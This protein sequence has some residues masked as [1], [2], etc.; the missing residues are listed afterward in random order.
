MAE[1]S[2]EGEPAASTT[3]GGW[4]SW[5]KTLWS[6]GSAGV[7]DE[8]VVKVEPGTGWLGGWFGGTA[9][10]SK[11]TEEDS[12]DEVGKSKLE[13]S[14]DLESKERASHAGSV[15]GGSEHDEDDS[16]S[17][18]ASEEPSRVESEVSGVNASTGNVSE[19]HIEADDAVK[20]PED[21]AKVA[22][23]SRRDKS[24]DAQQFS[25]S[26]EDA[27]AAGPPQSGGLW[28]SVSAW[29]SPAPVVVPVVVPCPEPPAPPPEKPPTPSP[30]PDPPI[31]ARDLLPVVPEPPPVNSFFLPER[32]DLDMFGPRRFPQYDG[33][34]R[35]W[36][37]AIAPRW[38]SAGIRPTHPYA[39][40][41]DGAEAMSLFRVS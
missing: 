10:T 35:G 27:K 6:Q 23:N 34:L 18:S 19:G 39:C 14:V 15:A 20:P 1:D 41:R 21:A 28:D 13:D 22:P 40:V 11:D 17:D 2:D 26:P 3:Q 5:Y 12:D 7:E 37:R 32:T 30:P 25:L 33:P 16:A 24:R 8:P 31:S 36:P 4:G 29:F 9:E 38:T